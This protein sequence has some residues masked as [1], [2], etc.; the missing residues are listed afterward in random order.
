MA[1][2]FNDIKENK[3]ASNYREPLGVS[4]QRGYQWP[5]QAQNGAIPFGVPTA[6]S[7]AAKEVLYPNGGSLEEKQANTKMYQKTHGNFAPGEQRTREYDWT[8]NPRI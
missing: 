3:Y 1:D 4:Y 7:L 5:E 8:S 6:E 2:K